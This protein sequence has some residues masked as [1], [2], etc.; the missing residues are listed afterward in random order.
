MN[1]VFKLVWNAQ[2]QAYIVTSEKAQS[3]SR[4]FLLNLLP[5]ISLIL[6][7]TPMSYAQCDNSLL[8]NN[9]SRRVTNEIANKN[10]SN[11]QLSN[12]QI[13]A[14]INSLFGATNFNNPVEILLS[15]HIESDDDGYNY[16]GD[17]SVSDI[18]LYQSAGDIIGGKNGININHNGNGST[19]ITISSDVTGKQGDGIRTINSTSTQGLNITELVGANV[20]GQANGINAVNNG[21]GI[22]I[23]ST[24]DSVI[25]DELDGISAVNDG[26][27]QGLKIIQS[28]G[29]IHGKKNGINADNRGKG[30]T[31]ITTNGEVVGDENEGINAVNEQNAGDLLISQNGGSITGGLNGIKANNQGNGSTSITVTA[32]II[33]QQ[34]DGINANNSSNTHDLSVTQNSGVINGKL[35]G[36]NAVNNGNGSTI[37]TTSGTVTGNE[38]D[39]VNITSQ[40]N[41]NKL[42]FNQIKG[43]ITGKE[44]GI[45][46]VNNGNGITSISSHGTI[47]GQQKDG[48]LATG[49]ANT[50]DL[51][52]NQT[53]GSI[54]GALNG[55]NLTNQGTG[56]TLI[57]TNGEIIGQQN[58]GL[59][60]VSQA[61]THDMTVN[62]SAGTILGQSNGINIHNGGNGSSIIGSSGDITGRTNYGIVAVNETNTK[63]LT[64]I[65]SS[66][67]IKGNQDG[68]NIEHK[69]TGST[70]IS[71]AGQVLGYQGNGIYAVTQTNS[72]NLTAK[73]SSGRIYGKK[74][75]I[76]FNNNGNG[77][78]YV[79]TFGDVIGE[80]NEGI[81]VNNDIHSQDVN[82]MQTSGQIKGN[83]NGIN[84][85]NKGRG[86][87]TVTSSADIIGSQYNAITLLND[88][89][90]Q[91]ITVSQLD[92]NMQGESYGMYIT[93]NGKS[94]TA[95]NTS[96]NVTGDQN[97][98]IRVFNNN[99][100]TDLKI[101]Q[102]KGNITGNQDAINIENNGQGLTNITT[103][104]NVIGKQR[105]GIAVKNG[106]N[107][108]SLT[109]IQSAGEINGNRYGI[110]A[111]NSG[112]NSTVIS[113]AGKV[114]GN[115]S[116]A[117]FAV[118]E[119][120][121]YN[122]LFS[123]NRG[124]E[125]NGK[126]NSVNLTNNGQ[127]STNIKVAGKIIS[128]TLD[129]IIVA[130]DANTSSLS[131]KQEADSNI[132]GEINGVNLT[133]KGRGLTN[134]IAQGD[135][136]A[137]QGSGILA[138]NGDT[139]TDLFVKQSNGVISGFDNGIMVTNNGT[140]MTELDISGK[141]VGQNNIMGIGINTSGK[142]GLKTYINLNQ[143]ADV[144]S[145][146]G[147]AIK[148]ETTDSIIALNN[149]SKVS[150][151]IRL[152]TGN[153]TLFINEGADI[154]QL[155]VVD[156]GNKLFRVDGSSDVD[157]LSLNTHLIGSSTSNG[158]IGDV[159]I[160]GWENINLS[161]IARL[162]LTGDL[163]TDKL[164]INSGAMVDLKSGLH[165][166][167]IS[168]SVYNSGVITL[169]NQFAGDRLTIAGDY[170]GDDGKL[171]FDTVVQNSDS[172]TDRLFVQGNVSGNTFIEINNIDGLGADTSNTNGIELVHVDG[173]S[174]NDA[175][176]MRQEH[177]DVGAYEY[178]LHKGDLNNQ[179]NNWYLR[180]YLPN[181]PTVPTDPNEPTHPVDPTTPIKPIDPT[182]PTRPIDPEPE[183][184]GKPA[185]IKT[186]RKEVSMFGAIAE[187]LRLADNLMQSN[188]HQ[189]IGN[190]P[191]LDSSI[192]WGRII[193]KRINVKQN[194]TANAHSKGNYSGFQLGSDIWQNNDWRIGG[195]FGYLHGNLSVD[196]FASGRYG[197]VGSNGINSYFMAAYST[198][199]QND[200]GYLDMVL[201]AARHRADV[202]PNSNKNSKQKANSLNASI[203]TGKPFGLF[204]SN[205]KI[206]PQ[207]QIIHQWLDLKDSH[208]NGKTK[209]KHSDNNA[210][211][212]RI[213]AR[214][215]GDYKADNEL[216]RPYARVNL[217]YSPS[218]A[219]HVTFASKSA[220]TKFS[221]GAKSFSSE[222][223]IG[224]S[225]EVNNQINAYSEIGHTLTHGGDA[226]VKAP[227][228]ASV[229]IR[230]KW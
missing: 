106:T 26:D 192:G 230:A 224:G 97:D 48:I 152:G 211:L 144:S 15:N 8:V 115:N 126:L 49:S 195:Y 208:I 77:S 68:I 153:D 104:D 18:T 125:I 83:A 17:N 190:A 91:D 47:E 80:E 189:R 66:G 163:N 21:H 209:V 175:F 185:R 194:G 186:Y 121:T 178:Y 57:T 89:N 130:N 122:L 218:G 95:I 201:Q 7:M 56:S 69:G 46:I 169:G 60:A 141:V 87:T 219:D 174:S 212:L 205:W 23:I 78:T 227:I 70:T 222:L 223:A 81:L 191:L 52:F 61:N 28:A 14:Y 6:V 73:Q 220:A 67:N 177:L 34:N 215:E 120:A 94:T 128:Q 181:N 138:A 226:R 110:Y 82:V 33:G 24:A 129:A 105:D 193:T 199:M 149:G 167:N 88:Q 200:G 30:R 38:K 197:R 75:G 71:T 100:A 221:N 25:G 20:H 99:S 214:F 19:G 166:S 32:N 187:Q 139:A 157:S 40:A 10:L 183:K 170:I 108:K 9:C 161:S 158:S 131:F 162:T 11:N 59:Y 140:G 113:I 123:Q 180:S 118:A 117:I 43:E 134:I 45:N 86:K 145:T 213:G 54:K 58:D 111:V 150:G 50:T 51:N 137:N 143:G 206:E 168:G 159:A 109:V 79:N 216:W 160:I 4:L 154:S 124:S 188:L 112:Q 27:T 22:T 74:S 146:S 62:Q 135:I 184:P 16:T 53:S 202:N 92:G 85:T 196:G 101:N 65:Q 119:S 103:S 63:D 198:Y 225:Y 84:I 37:V 3:K 173:S 179:N 2:R 172:P 93:N 13:N 127:G 31:N 90:S 147:I 76:N 156:G 116:D 142:E 5:A 44:Y 96:G 42:T 182:E 64:I 98:A 114:I 102:L 72:Q 133:N 229:G 132:K 1:K 36:I 210:L 107:S 136:S 151:Q 29:N 41:T 204:D 207:A 164:T 203:E 35:N 155:T 12:K 39:G 55:M 228:S 148:N 176:K 171:I 165:Q 217:F